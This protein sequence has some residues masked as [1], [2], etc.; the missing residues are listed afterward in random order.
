MS[1][2]R[3]KRSRNEPTL[4]LISDDENNEDQTS[5]RDMIHELLKTKVSR[6]SRYGTEGTTLVLT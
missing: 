5:L 1:K 4:E 3:S 6:D 2:S